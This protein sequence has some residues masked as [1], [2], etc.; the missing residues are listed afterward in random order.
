MNRKMMWM[1]LSV[2]VMAS[3]ILSACAPAA[4][5]APTQAPATQKPAEVKPTDKP[6]EPTMVPEVKPT[7][8]PAAEAVSLRWR[9]RPDNKEEA[10]VYASA[11]S[12]THLTLPTTILV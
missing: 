1:V 2:L 9:T 8:A 12:Y 11:V 4:T 6:A 10:G 7:E 5:P 3:L